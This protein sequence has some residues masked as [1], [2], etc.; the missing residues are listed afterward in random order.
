M[1]PWKKTV[2]TVVITIVVMLVAIAVVF[3]A[4]IPMFYKG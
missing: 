2:L 3:R 4:I 1:K